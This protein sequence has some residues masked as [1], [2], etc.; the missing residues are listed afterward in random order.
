MR[1]GALVL[2]LALTA[3]P[4]MA[5]RGFSGSLLLSLTEHRTD[6]GF[7]LERSSGLVFG[8]VAGR[9]LGPQVEVALHVAGGSLD[10]STPGAVDRD[11][12]EIGLTT[13]VGAMPWL[14]LR[15]R[16]ARRVYSTPIARQAWTLVGVEAE[17]RVAFTEQHTRALARLGLLPVAS[18]SGMPRPDFAFTAAAGLEQ[19]VGAITLR[20]LYSL[21]RY[22]FPTRDGA[23]RREQLSVLT[24]QARLAAGRQR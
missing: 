7:G 15:A 12:G 17:A 18:A 14:A 9:W 23:P 6:A 8:A 5:Q 3:H 20:A 10:A 13:T 2:A 1:A 16:A 22:D 24:L 19:A 4:S 21:E 11:L